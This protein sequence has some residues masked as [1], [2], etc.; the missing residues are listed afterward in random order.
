[1][2]LGSAGCWL[3]RKK[4]GTLSGLSLQSCR[5]RSARRWQTGQTAIEKHFAA[6]AFASELLLSR[7]WLVIKNGLDLLKLPEFEMQEMKPPISKPLESMEFADVRGATSRS[8]F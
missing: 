5:A 6:F 7:E 3:P 2:L 8:R 4:M 1:M